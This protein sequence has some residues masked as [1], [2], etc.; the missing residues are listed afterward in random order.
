M[1]KVA[2]VILNWNGRG[3]LEKFLPSVL[4][5]TK[6]KNS[7]IYVVDNNSSDDSVLFIEKNFPSVKLIRFSENYGFAGG[8]ARSLPQINAEYYILLNSDIEVTANW[9]TPIIKIM[10][11]DKSIAAYM[12]KIK[13]YMNKN[14]FEYA[15][16]AGGFI[17]K[18]GYPFCRGRILNCIEE[19]KGQ[20]DNKAEIFWASGA[21]M[22]LRSSAYFEAGGLDESFFAHM[23][24]ID[25]CWRLKRLDYKIMYCPDVTVYHVGGG[26]LPNN[27]PRKIFLNYRN[28]LFLLYKNLSKQKLL[29]VLIMRIFLDILSSIVYLLKFSVSFSLAVFKAHIF[30]YLALPDLKKKRKMILNIAK[31]KDGLYV[32]SESIVKLF[33]LKRIKKFSDLD[34]TD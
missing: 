16:A 19:D 18:Y 28:N 3:F 1:Y 15:G 5:N 20:Y 30:F 25:L 2:V 32:F 31:Q 12:P 6:H 29:P 27:N 17:D 11:S 4:L 8:Y 13:S 7:V 9:I 26:T 22:F 21:C 34:F 24:E 10:D 23:E 33:F 14:S